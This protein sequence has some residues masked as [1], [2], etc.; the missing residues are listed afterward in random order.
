LTLFD[1]IAQSIKKDPIK[2]ENNAV[3]HRRLRL[4]NLM[5]LTA[6]GTPFIHSGQE[7]GHTKQFRDPTYRYP[8]SEDKVPN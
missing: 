4:E 8:V 7:Y 2:S 1:I 5:V 3:I 6:Q